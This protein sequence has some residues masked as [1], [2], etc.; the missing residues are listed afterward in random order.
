[1]EKASLRG[2]MPHILLAGAAKYIH[3]PFTFGEVLDLQ[4][5]FACNVLSRHM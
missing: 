2:I 4:Q 1:M 3:Q 5:Y